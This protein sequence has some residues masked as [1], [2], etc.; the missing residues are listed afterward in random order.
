VF[1]RVLAR[2]VDADFSGAEFIEHLIQF[3]LGTPGEMA[4]GRN[5]VSILIFHIY[6]L[7]LLLLSV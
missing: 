7:S 6:L 5:M 2:L 4:S 1:R 3:L